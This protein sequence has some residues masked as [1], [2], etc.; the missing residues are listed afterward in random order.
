MCL[1]EWRQDLQVVTV[2]RNTSVGEE[3]VN[4]A[5]SRWLVEGRKRYSDLC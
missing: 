1:G 3:L 5:T 4:M 2:V